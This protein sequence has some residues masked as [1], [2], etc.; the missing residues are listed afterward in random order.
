MTRSRLD[1]VQIAQLTYDDTKQATKVALVGAEFAVQLNAEEGDSVISKK[2]TDII[3]LTSPKSIL[4]LSMV[5]K[6][7]L[8][9]CDSALLRIL[10]DNEEVYCYTL[11][12]GNTVEIMAQKVEVELLGAEKAYLL[13]K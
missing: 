2:K 12:K 11:T 13:V 5:E 9:G 8:Y 7:C 3:P 6:V 10:L 1:P 4:D